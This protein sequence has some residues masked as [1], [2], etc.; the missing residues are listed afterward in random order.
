M[1]LPKMAAL[2]ALPLLALTGCHGDAL[3]VPEHLKA[4]NEAAAQ[5]KAL[6]NEAKSM[7]TAAAATARKA[8][9]EA[10]RAAN[11]AESSAASAAK[12]AEEA[13]TAADKAEQIFNKS[14]RK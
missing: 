11:A 6:A 4:I 13:K 10:G 7:A 9:E 5:N 1:R 12:A 2:A 3:H 14:L 8:M